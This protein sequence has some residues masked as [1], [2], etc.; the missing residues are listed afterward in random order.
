MN[1][2]SAREFLDEI[3]EFERTGLQGTILVA[4]F[5][6][7]ELIMTVVQYGAGMADK[8]AEGMR[9]ARANLELAKKIQG[10]SGAYCHLGVLTRLGRA[11][12]DEVIQKRVALYNR[13]LEFYSVN[14]VP[15]IEGL[16]PIEF[17]PLR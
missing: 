14:G 17:Q 9:G 3:R 12:N 8:I 1:G 13:M 16:T 4:D 10:K 11:E 6:C 5:A 7:S 2:T 15:G